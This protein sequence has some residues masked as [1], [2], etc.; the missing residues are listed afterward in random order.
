MEE[1]CKEN[2]IPE[3][4]YLLHSAYTMKSIT[5]I[6]EDKIKEALELLEK[7]YE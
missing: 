7:T 1:I 2:D 3:G 6:R 4:T 5:L